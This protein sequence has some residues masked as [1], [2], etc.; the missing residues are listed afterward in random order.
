MH[1]EVL[2]PTEDGVEK[3]DCVQKPGVVPGVEDSAGDHGNAG[4]GSLKEGADS[5]PREARG[6]AGFAQHHLPDLR[7]QQEQ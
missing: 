2:E 6:A 4:Q 5:R 1:P 7:S 3:Q